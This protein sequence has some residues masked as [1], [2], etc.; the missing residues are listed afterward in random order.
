MNLS[1]NFPALRSSLFDRNPSSLKGVRSAINVLHNMGSSLAVS[2]NILD[3]VEGASV[4]SEPVATSLVQAEVQLL[5]NEVE[6]KKQMDGV[7]S[8]GVLEGVSNLTPSWTKIVAPKPDGPRMKLSYHPPPPP[9][10]NKIKE[11]RV[12]VCPP[13]EVVD[14]G[15]SQWKDCV[16]GYFLDKKLP[17][18][19]V[20]SIAFQI[21]KRFGIQKVMSND[22]GFF[23]FKFSQ[24]DGHEKVVAAGPWHFG[25][26]LLILKQWSPQ[27]E[28]KKE[29]FTKVPIWAQLYNVPLQLWH[30]DGLSFIASAI[31]V[32]L[33]AEKPT[34]S[35]KRLSYARLC[36]EVE[37]GSIL[38]DTI[39]VECSTGLTATL[40]C[41]K[42]KT[43]WVRN[44]SVVAPEVCSLPTEETLGPQGPSE[45]FETMVIT[46]KSK[47]KQGEVCQAGIEAVHYSTP[48]KSASEVLG[49]SPTVCSDNSFSALALLEDKAGAVDIDE[50]GAV[51]TEEEIISLESVHTDQPDIV[52][53]PTTKRGRGK[54]KGIGG[55]PNT[56]K[57]VG[58]GVIEAK[59][60]LENVDNTV[61]R[62]FPAHWLS[63]H[64][65]SHGT[66]W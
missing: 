60:R 51:L 6:P 39:D 29:Q 1:T 2:G 53:F 40:R 28:L 45:V 9:P 18:S 24:A 20:E 16:V 37:V 50:T 17:F 31:G 15:V 63:V 42:P 54:S 44:E 3:C 36:V 8:T 65:A 48:V 5:R 52:I 7:I 26:K 57:G 11:A 58:G 61:K 34:E 14:V 56:K 21:W 30:E 43:E 47:R 22:Q 64:N 49:L 25:E 59:V 32:P 12:V 19:A 27:L 46:E 38:P 4:V 35:C 55:P 13:P 66:Y 62:C 23:F 41:Q 33:Y 10:Q